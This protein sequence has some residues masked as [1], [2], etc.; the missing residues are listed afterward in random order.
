MSDLD[1]NIASLLPEVDPTLR[2]EL[3]QLVRT[4]RDLGYAEGV[5]DLM[6][7]LSLHLTSQIY[8]DLGRKANSDNLFSR[9]EDLSRMHILPDEVSSYLQLIRTLSNKPHHDTA[10]IRL[11][12]SD[13]ENVLRAFLRVMEWYY[14]EWSDNP[15]RLCSIYAQQPVAPVTLRDELYQL[16]AAVATKAAPALKSETIVG[17]RPAEVT[18]SFKDRQ[19]EIEELRSLIAQEAVKLICILGRG[20]IGKT[21]L[22]ASICRE[23]ETGKLRISDAAKD[24]GADGIIYWTCRD[25]DLPGL[26][27]LF[28][29]YARVLGSPNG[30]ALMGCWRDATRSRAD[31]IEFLL[32]KLRSGCYLLV[33]DNL[34]AALGPDNRMKDADLHAFMEAALSTHH[35]LRILTTSRERLSLGSAELR[36]AR[37]IPLEQGLPESDGVSLLRELDISGELGLREGTGELLREIVR[38]CCG[39]PRALEAVVG[40]LVNDPTLTAEALVSDDSLFEKQLVEVL[41]AQNYSRVPDDQKRVLEVLSAFNAPVPF[42]FIDQVV[43]TFFPT[44]RVEECLRSLVRSYTVRYQRTQQLYF[45]HPIDQQHAYGKIPNAGEQ[46]KKAA[47][48]RCAAEVFRQQQKKREEWKG[49][50]DLNATLSA[51]THLKLA[52]D[53]DDACRLMD[54]VDP[55]PLSTWGHYQLTCE[56]R[57]ALVGAQRD[58]RLKGAN[59]GKIGLAYANMGQVEEAI[60]R[61]LDSLDL[62]RKTGDELT[63]ATRLGNLGEAYFVLG[64][65]D[66]AIQYFHSAQESCERLGA[67][68]EA[69]FWLGHIGLVHMRTGCLDKASGYFEQAAQI[70]SSLNEQRRYGSWLSNLG[71]LRLAQGQ[72]ESALEYYRMATAIADAMGDR[73]GLVAR[74]HGTG[75]CLV[76]IGRIEEALSLYQKAYDIARSIHSRFGQAT[77]LCSIGKIQRHLGQLAEARA[78]L[79]EAVAIDCPTT[80]YICVLQLGIVE[81]LR[82]SSGKEYFDRSAVLC[83]HV[84]ERTPKNYDALYSRTLANVGRGERQFALEDLRQAK[85]ICSAEGVVTDVSRDLAALEGVVGPLPEMDALL[86]TKKSLP[87]SAPDG[88]LPANVQSGD[89]PLTA[90]GRSETNG[91]P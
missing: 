8:A 72:I 18:S 4:L 28:D 70:A 67:S 82:G 9:I 80:N 83:S 29:D 42:K 23:I 37:V 30:E 1:Q 86:D 24:Q 88:G 11:Q 46:Y 17:V 85:A 73:R 60:T 15:H 34:E 13:A 74:L 27:R 54:T 22:L 2:N 71:S 50:S 59:L 44:I 63:A 51:V 26:S 56:L 39:I 32:S 61:Y 12:I 89:N 62:A 69:G 78:S 48:H 36:S 68:G 31:K 6:M 52:G 33:L 41:I 16:R 43:R 57:K 45:L 21:A 87:H 35:A 5:L 10:K 49:L 91:S 84:L 65:T 47:C 79:S 81:L 53:A 3:C 75:R 7:R 25:A 19:D 90:K 14:C 76:E 77:S 58:E 20:G 55:D 66:K 40:M 64:E 38:R